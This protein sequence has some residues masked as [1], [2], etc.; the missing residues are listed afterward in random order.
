MELTK[1]EMYSVKGGGISW[2]V[3]GGISALITYIVGIFSGYT[4]PSSCNN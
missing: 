1:N 4:N 2:Y 3:I